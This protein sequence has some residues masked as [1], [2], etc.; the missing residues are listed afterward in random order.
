MIEEYNKL[1]NSFKQTLVFHV[2]WRAGFFSEYN[3]MILAMIFC[4]INK[5]KFV[6]YSNDATFKYQTG[7]NDYFLPF[8]EST[9]NPIHKYLNMR[10]IQLKITEIKN[11]KTL[12]WYI[13]INVFNLLAKLSKPFVSFD[14]Y[15]QDLWNKIRHLDI[16]SN[17][18]IPALA[19]NGNLLDACN[20]MVK[21]TWN[22]N[23]Q[24]QNAINTLISSVQ[25]PK[26]YVGL[27]IRRGDKSTETKLLDRQK[28][29]DK[30]K[31]LSD[32]RALFIS[33]DDYQ[34]I[35]DISMEYKEYVI[36]TLCNK[37]ERGYFQEKFIKQDKEMIKRAHENLF[38]SIDLL[39]NAQ[40]FIG[41]FTSNLGIFLGM[42]M[43]QNKIT[44]IDL[45]KWQIW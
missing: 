30:V 45:D 22:Y 16:D 6:L 33:T 26:K 37:D 10:P 15:T 2:G 42:R 43:P 8:C 35:E 32:I 27:H 34:I 20:V 36:Y 19:I 1:N 3:N 44:S 24:T 18:C 38:A 17:Y 5:I 31:P 11:L 14:Y 7:W 25:L 40:Y 41:T 39:N 12:N 23:T 4:I 28:Y 21:L 29:M 13:K 9:N